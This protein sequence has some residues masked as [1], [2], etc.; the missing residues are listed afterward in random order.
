MANERSCLSFFSFLR[1]VWL[2]N[3]GH[4][5]PH[6]VGLAHESSVSL[7]EAWVGPQQCGPHLGPS[8]LSVR[9]PNYRLPH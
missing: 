8:L 5:C 3:K 7:G 4:I 1:V 2:Y 6:T 9:R